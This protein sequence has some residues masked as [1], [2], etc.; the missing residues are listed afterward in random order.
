MAPD[1][2][3]KDRTEPIIPEF[4]RN[5]EPENAG[6]ET[7]QGV[8][9]IRNRGQKEQNQPQPPGF[10]MPRMEIPMYEDV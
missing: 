6:I 7:E 2:P 8:V 5:R 9:V 3:P 10:P 1:F 4:R